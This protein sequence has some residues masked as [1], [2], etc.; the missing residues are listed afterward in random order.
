[1][2]SF[3]SKQERHQEHQIYA[4]SDEEDPAAIP[5]ATFGRIMVI[6]S[7]K[8][9]DSIITLFNKDTTASFDYQIFGTNK[10]IQLDNSPFGI[11]DP[12]A[13]APPVADPSW[14]NLLSGCTDPAIFEQDKFKTIPAMTSK[15]GIAKETFS[16]KWSYVQILAKT[17]KP[18]GLIAAVLHRGTNEH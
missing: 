12:E 1:M 6:D 14:V 15:V 18:G 11:S 4:I 7:R 17:A 5:E 8:Y 10:F 3:R 13:D 16:N 9:S 2:A